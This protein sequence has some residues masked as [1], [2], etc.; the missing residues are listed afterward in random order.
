MSTKTTFK[1][2][3]LVAVAALGLGVLSVVPS[4]AAV[5]SD[6]LV[7]SNT[8]GTATNA[9]AVALGDT[10]TATTSARVKFTYLPSAGAADSVTVTASL[11]S[12]PADNTALPKMSV[13]DTVSATVFSGLSGTSAGTQLNYNPANAG[14]NTVASNTPVG[15]VPASS[16]AITSATFNV[17]LATS[18][19]AGTLKAGTYVV[20]VTPKALDGSDL[21]AAAVTLTFT[22]TAPDTTAVAAYTH[23]LAVSPAQAITA[24]ST[25]YPVVGQADS[26]TSGSK[27][28][29]TRIGSIG[30]AL[31]NASNA[32][33][34]AESFT[35]TITG[36]GT[37]GAGAVGANAVGTPSG[38][39]ISVKNG[40]DVY[41]Y[42]DGTGGV[43]TITILS[44]KGVVLATKSV[45]FWGDASVVVLSSNSNAVV[46]TLSANLKATV[47]DAAGYVVEGVQLYTTSSD[48]TVIS[49]SYSTV[50]KKTSSKGEA[51]ISL[52]GVKL[53][54][55]KITVG[56]ATSA[57]DV[58]TTG[59]AVK[60]DALTVTVGG[61][62]TEQAGV[63]VTTD[64]Q[65]YTPGSYAYITVKAV[66]KAGKTLS[67]RP[68]TTADSY[69]VFATGGITASLPVEKVTG[70]LA[71]TGFIGAAKAGTA[72]TAE[73][74]VALAGE[75]V[76][77]VKLPTYA[78]DLTFSWTTAAASFFPA[79]V[80]AG[81][82]AGSVTVSLS[83]PGS[84]A[85]VDAAAEATDAA[86]AA[87]DAA[88]AAADAADA[89]TAAAEDASAAVAQLSKSVTTALNNLKKQITSLTALVNKLLK[90]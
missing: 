57:T 41:I 18:N 68:S 86:N 42:G 27:V 45:N 87:T 89:A 29:G 16:G 51:D 62:T 39:S 4:S 43:G 75:Y 85:A 90:K 82:V 83:D 52:T 14:A 40:H 22:V 32:A 25:T 9:F 30:V 56:L 24:N 11:V 1:R 33:V 53:G 46:G 15:I 35:A 38:R 54:T 6:T 31:L 64:K 20:K 72:T 59:Y 81:G 17:W 55:A 44:A 74:I 79:N 67:P 26:V 71:N 12:A 70:D 28:A 76:Y 2:I 3:A 23:L 61:S 60:S 37:L 77:K 78:G 65:A 69:T 58:T 8:A 50:A 36:A 84:Q 49:N 88:L 13:S 73:P 47:Y 5:N 80:A 66:D 7:A 63:V 19:T 21:N 10:I 34:T 48:I